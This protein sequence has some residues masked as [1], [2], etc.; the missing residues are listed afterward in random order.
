MEKVCKFCRSRLELSNEYLVLLSTCK[1]RLRYIRKR[2]PQISEVIQFTF[3][4]HLV[5]TVAILSGA[6]RDQGQLSN[7]SGIRFRLLRQ[8]GA[9]VNPMQIDTKN[10][11]H[12]GSRPL[13]CST[14]AVSARGD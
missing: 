1:I 7:S 10:R 2:A 3:T 8:P 11:D 12:P 13:P 6:P 4:I 9:E 14:Q 5:V